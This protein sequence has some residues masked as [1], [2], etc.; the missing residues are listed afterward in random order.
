M[1]EHECP[2]CLKKFK[3][4]YS[5][6][7]HLN[8]KNPCDSAKNSHLKCKFC[9]KRFCRKDSLNRHIK[10]MHANITKQIK[11]LNIDG[12]NNNVQSVMVDKLIHNHNGDVI[13]NNYFVLCP[14]SK[15]EIDKLSTND[16]IC[17]FS[18]N[19]NPIIM[20]VVKT[21]LNPET[22]EYHNVGY[23]DLNSGYGYIF[24]GK[25]WITKDIKSIINEIFNSKQNDLIKIH[26]EIKNFLSKEQ[27]KL[28]E[29]KLIE[30]RDCVEPRLETAIFNSYNELKTCVIPIR[31]CFAISN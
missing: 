28:I 23:K 13:N 27:N 20:I 24:N 25:T 15:E 4:K 26:D 8:K 17:I 14:F 21:N 18:S 2:N 16:K 7:R 12:D 9:N 30:I 3:K 19:E 11:K 31:N 22:I 29:N 1:V 6:E 10:T 5:L